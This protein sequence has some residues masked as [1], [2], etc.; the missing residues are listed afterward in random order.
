MSKRLAEHVGETDFDKAEPTDELK[1]TSEMG[2]EPNDIVK[3]LILWPDLD[4]IDDSSREQI[5]RY[6]EARR[7]HI[8][9]IDARETLSTVPDGHRQRFLAVLPQAAGR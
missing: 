4:L 5:W 1:P 2:I 9:A 6:L 8:T 3:T 7:D